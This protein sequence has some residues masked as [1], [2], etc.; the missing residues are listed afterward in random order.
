MKCCICDVEC[1]EI[2][3]SLG[4][5]WN[6]PKCERT[7]TDWEEDHEWP[8]DAPPAPGERKEAK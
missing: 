2:S 6:C 1:E 7:W 3:T 5:E 8:E 4:V